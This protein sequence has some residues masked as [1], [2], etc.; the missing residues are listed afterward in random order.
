LK[1]N[2]GVL[3][4]SYARILFPIND[5]LELLGDLEEFQVGFSA[6]LTSNKKRLK[7]QNSNKSEVLGDKNP[8]NRINRKF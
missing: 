3:L 1:D 6:I 4:F 8:I 5:F 2:E 7:I